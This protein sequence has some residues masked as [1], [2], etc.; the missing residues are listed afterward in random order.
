MN[1]YAWAILKIT[2]M[3]ELKPLKSKDHVLSWMNQGVPLDAE[4]LELTREDILEAGAESEDEV[5][6]I[7]QLLIEHCQK[8]PLDNIRELE[9]S[10][11]KNLTQKEIDRT[12]RRVRKAKERRY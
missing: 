7:Q 9:L 1:D 10:L 12:I 3:R 8:K 2:K 4:D 6:A 11:V 5:T